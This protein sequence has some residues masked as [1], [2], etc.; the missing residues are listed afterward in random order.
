MTTLKEAIEHNE[1]VIRNVTVAL[2]EN[3][4]ADPVQLITNKTYAIEQIMTY[5][6]AANITREMLHLPKL[7]L[8]NT[9]ELD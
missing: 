5:I 8:I 1:R 4:L 6:Q 2:I 3:E 9:N 7:Y